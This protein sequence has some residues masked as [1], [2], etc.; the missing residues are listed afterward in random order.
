MF[1]HLTVREN[2]AFGAR[3]Q[4]EVTAVADIVQEAIERFQL[5]GMAEKFPSML[6]GGERQRVS[7]ARALM[8][9][10]EVLLLDEPTSGLDPETALGVLTNVRRLAEEQAMS[11]VMVTH[12]LS[13][14]RLMSTH[15]LM[16]EAGSVVEAGP[17]R[18]LFAR[19]HTERARAYLAS[20]GDGGGGA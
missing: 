20:E 16:L 9:A 5:P 1:P 13:E 8:T 19:A 15:T 14:A 11:V 3:S 4:T 12:R 18:E 2:I 7:I 10:P 17:T 6:S